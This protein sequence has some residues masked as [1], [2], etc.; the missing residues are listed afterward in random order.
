MLELKTLPGRVDRTAIVQRMEEARAALDDLE[1]SP[2][3]ATD[4]LDVLRGARERV[5]L[6]AEALEGHDLSSVA[7]QLCRRIRGVERALEHAREATIEAIVASQQDHISDELRGRARERVPGVQ[8]FAVSPGVPRLHA[9]ARSLL[10]A[11]VDVVP[12]D[13]IFDDEDELD[14]AEDEAAVSE[15][16]P[17]Y[18]SDLALMAEPD[19]EEEDEPPPESVDPVKRLAVL[20]QPGGAAPV[21]ATMAFGTAGE[22]AQLERL[23]RECL[24][25]ISANANLRR[26][27]DEDRYDWEAMGRFEQRMCASLD[28]L[29]ALTLLDFGRWLPELKKHFF[30]VSIPGVRMGPFPYQEDGSIELARPFVIVADA[31]TVT[32]VARVVISNAMR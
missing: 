4:H 27:G 24:E 15:L 29:V 28:A 1:Q 9:I 3:G 22:L 20:G 19:E 18:E 32:H 6:A 31:Q 17:S 10:K 14:E 12:E 23:A 11:A 26:L 7:M 30:R 8:P 2:L 16:E 25:D 21:E 13:Y 5:K